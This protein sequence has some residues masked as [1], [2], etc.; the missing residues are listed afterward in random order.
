MSGI[1]NGIKQPLRFYDAVEKQNWRRCWVHES[2]FTNANTVICAQNS[3][4][5]FQ[6]RRRRSPNPVTVFDLYTLSGSDF[7]YDLDLFTLCS[8]SDTINVIQ[9][10]QADNL[11]WNPMENFNQDI[12]CGI[13]YIVVGDGVHTWYSEVFRTVNFDAREKISLSIMPDPVH[14]QGVIGTSKGAWAFR[15]GHY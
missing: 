2:G 3:I 6:I 8:G 11:V 12:D 7:V 10:Q 5:P 13:H 14:A 4:I 9:M 1:N 15:R